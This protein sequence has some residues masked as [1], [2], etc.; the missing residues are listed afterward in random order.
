ML[1]HPVPYDEVRGARFYTSF[2]DRRS[3]PRFMRLGYDATREA[4]ETLGTTF[5]TRRRSAAGGVR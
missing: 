4:L 3:W 2:L 1:L 5:T